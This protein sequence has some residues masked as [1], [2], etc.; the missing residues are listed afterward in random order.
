MLMMGHGGGSG[1]WMLERSTNRKFYDPNCIFVTKAKMHQD[2][3]NK[4]ILKLIILY[5]YQYENGNSFLFQT[6]GEGEK[7]RLKFN[8]S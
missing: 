8:Q 1:W 3:S 6:L 7:K 5:L 2:K 4:N